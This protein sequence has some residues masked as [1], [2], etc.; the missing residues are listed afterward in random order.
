MIDKKIILI[1]I[2]SFLCISCMKDELNFE[3][4]IKSR[5]ENF[6]EKESLDISTKKVE[7]LLK[8]KKNNCKIYENNKMVNNRDV[9]RYEIKK[10]KKLLNKI[11]KKAKIYLLPVILLQK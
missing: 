10:I 1:I 2:I 5:Y 9:N 4:K 7:I 6:S 8:C 11:I 3:L